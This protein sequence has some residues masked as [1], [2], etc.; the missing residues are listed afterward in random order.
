MI[1]VI[2]QTDHLRLGTADTNFSPWREEGPF[3][4]TKMSQTQDVTG[5][6]MDALK[7]SCFQNTLKN[8]R[9]EPWSYR[10]ERNFL[11]RERLSG[12]THGRV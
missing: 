8:K 1:M 12:E 6:S 9:L 4:V 2:S 7:D 10:Q 3:M 11:D 5:E